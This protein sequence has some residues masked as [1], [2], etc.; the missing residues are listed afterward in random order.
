MDSKP[1]ITAAKLDPLFMLVLKGA[2]KW[3]EEC[4]KAEKY[5]RADKQERF[6]SSLHQWYLSGRD[7]KPAPRDYLYRDK[8]Q[9][10]QEIRNQT[11]KGW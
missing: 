5:R 1:W 6:L 10:M 2:L 9:I 7:K 8:K 4:P 3:L 11:S